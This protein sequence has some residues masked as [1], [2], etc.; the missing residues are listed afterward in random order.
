MFNKIVHILIFVFLKVFNLV[1]Y[2][3]EYFRGVLGRIAILN[4]ADFNILLELIPDILVVQPVN[5]N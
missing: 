2:F 1:H 5:S 3:P 4:K